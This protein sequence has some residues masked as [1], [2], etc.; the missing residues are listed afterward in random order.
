MDG[1]IR[2]RVG[3]SGGTQKDPT[4]HNLGDHSETVQMDFDPTR[5]SYEELLEIFWNSHSPESRS[6]STQY[7]IALFYHNE[8]QK[9]LALESRGR[10]AE[11][12]KGKVRTEILPA[13]EF[14]L[15]ENYHQKYYLQL[16]PVLMRDFR[17]IYPNSSDFI[18]STA[19]A[20][21]N[22]YIGGYGSKADF[23]ANL[24]LLGLSP[25]GSKRLQEIVK[26]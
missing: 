10:V 22:G 18:N 2:T 20:R 21:V 25:E 23:Q 26:R 8:E 13:T 6:W 16:S 5:L 4:Y 11:R 1:V 12:M 14:Y 15:A 17:A 9:R 3:Y 19:A 7:K 24:G